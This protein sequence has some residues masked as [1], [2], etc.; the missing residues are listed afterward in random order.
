MTVLLIGVLVG[1]F[2]T[3]VIGN[4]SLSDFGLNLFTEMLGVLITIFVIDSLVRRRE[5]KRQLPLNLSIYRDTF[6]FFGQ[7]IT[8]F[9]PAYVVSVPL[10]LPDS[11]EGFISENGMGKVFKYLDLDT[12]QPRVAPAKTWYQQFRERSISIT[13][14]GDTFLER[15][16]GLTDPMVF[17]A[18]HTLINGEFFRSIRVMESIRNYGLKSGKKYTMSFRSFGVRFSEKEYQSLQILNS[19]IKKGYKELSKFDSSIPQYTFKTEHHKQDLSCKLP[20]EL[21]M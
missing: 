21:I 14:L 7:F 1:S 20:D 6:K 8:I 17:N 5:S 2:L 12:I 4:E 11:L 10:E 13:K 9:H 16:R 15:Y 18:V 19:W 3:W